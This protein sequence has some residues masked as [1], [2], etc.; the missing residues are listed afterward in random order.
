[1]TEAPQPAAGSRRPGTTWWPRCAPPRPKAAAEHDALFQGV[2]KPEVFAYASFHLTGFMNEKPLATCARPGRAGPGARRAERLETEDHIAYLLEVMR[3]LIAGDD[4]AVCNLEQ[5]RRFFRAHLQTLGGGSCATATVAH[6]RADRCGVRWPPSPANSC[7][8]RRRASTCSKPDRGPSGTPVS[9]PDDI[10]GLILAAAAAAAWAASTRACR[11][12]RAC[13]WPCMP[14]APVAAGGPVDDQ[15]QPQPGGLRIL[16]VPVWPDPLAD[17]P[18][19]LAGLAGRL[20]ALR[21]A[22]LVS[23]PCDSPHFPTD[24][25]ARLARSPGARRRRCRHGR[26]LEDGRLQPQPVFCLLRAT[27]LESLVAFLPRVSAR[28]TA[29]PASTL[30]PGAVRRRRRLRQRQHRRRTGRSS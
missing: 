8:S 9:L 29:G 18:G 25:V 30:V 11:T 1:V 26:T 4:M 3:Y 6:P 7:S 13:R 27:L 24:L 2:G 20:G 16:G 5:Q 23:V 22:L 17:Y 15:R 19:P 21:D 14:A 28:S 10:T 12:T